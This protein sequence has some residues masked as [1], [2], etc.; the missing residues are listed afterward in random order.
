MKIREALQKKFVFC[1]RPRLKLIRITGSDRKD[2]MQRL[3]TQNMKE[4]RPGVVRPCAFLNANG[5][6]VSLFSV[7]EK[8][9][10]VWL[11]IDQSWIVPTLQFLKKMHFGEDLKFDISRME[12]YEARGAGLPKSWQASL[13]SKEDINGVLPAWPAGV[14]GVLLTHSSYSFVEGLEITEDQMSSLM[15]RL[16][17][18][19]RAEH[20]DSTNIILEGPLNDFIH[21]NKGCYPGQE[22]IERIFTYGNVAKQMV[23]VE[24]SG[25]TNDTIV[26]AELKLDG[27]T[28]GKI[29]A[30]G[31]SLDGSSTFAIAAIKRLHIN[32]EKTYV[33][34]GWPGCFA[35]L[36]KSY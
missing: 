13:E 5:T 20:F 18:P 28:V 4:M 12:I 25:N 16:G 24:F 6:V 26:G 14:P 3:S 27:E 17:V 2:F 32:P 10:E 29:Q 8:E 1:L 21:R 33:V 36:S 30:F 34:D 9:A 23:S 35:T 7:W 15:V 22:V 19:H 11:V 31:E